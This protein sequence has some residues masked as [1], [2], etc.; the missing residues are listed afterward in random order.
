MQMYFMIQEFYDMAEGALLFHSSTDQVRN[1]VGEDLYILLKN[2][3]ATFKVKDLDKNKCLRLLGLETS[4]YHSYYDEETGA[5]DQIPDE[6][7]VNI[8]NMLEDSLVTGCVQI[9]T[10]IHIDDASQV[11]S[12]VCKSASVFDIQIAGAPPGW[13]GSEANDIILGLTDT[14]TISLKRL[15]D[16]ICTDFVNLETE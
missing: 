10:N 11:Q 6:Y 15:F 16:R 13:K 8:E 3:K 14:A 7:F 4:F 9:V 12:K 5:F 1:I 2:E